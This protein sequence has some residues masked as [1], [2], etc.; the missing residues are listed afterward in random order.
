MN[1]LYL[2]FQTQ[3]QSHMLNRSEIITSELLVYFLVV[4]CKL[5]CL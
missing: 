5:S 1:L 4:A 3:F 2:W